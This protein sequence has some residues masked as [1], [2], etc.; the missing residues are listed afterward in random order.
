M[1]KIT[2]RKSVIG[3]TPRNRATVRALGLTKTGRSVLQ[4][5]TPSIRGMVHHVKHLLLVE[6]VD[7]ERGPRK[8]R[9]K[10]KPLQEAKAPKPAKA[11]KAEAAAEPKPKPAPKKAPAKKPAAKKEET[12]E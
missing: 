9:G 7:A 4:E 11:P 12:S 10:A 8:R 6:E 3:N 5:D 2:L 1:L